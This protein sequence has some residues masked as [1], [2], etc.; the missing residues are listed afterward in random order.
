MPG[1]GIV[2][3]A[4]LQ[5]HGHDFLDALK[6][7]GRFRAT[8]TTFAAMGTVPDAT[9]FTECF[10]PFEGLRIAGIADKPLGLGKGRRTEEVVIH[11]QGIAVGVTGT[12]HDTGARI[13]NHQEGFLGLVPFFFRRGFFGL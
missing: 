3:H 13:I 9:W 8:L 1:S 2:V 10:D 6:R 5:R 12:A 7:T 11:L 4:L